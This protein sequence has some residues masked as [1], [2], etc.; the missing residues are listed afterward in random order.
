[1][2]NDVDQQQHEWRRDERY[3]GCSGGVVHDTRPSGGDAGDIRNDACD[4]IDGTDELSGANGAFSG[5]GGSECGVSGRSESPDWWGGWIPSFN[6]DRIK[7]ITNHVFGHK[8]AIGQD[9]EEMGHKEEE[10]GVKREEDPGIGQMRQSLNAP[11]GK[12]I[13]NLGR[14]KPKNLGGRSKKVGDYEE[15]ERD[16]DRHKVKSGKSRGTRTEKREEKGMRPRSGDQSGSEQSEGNESSSVGIWRKT[17]KRITSRLGL[18]NGVCINKNWNN[19]VD[20]MGYDDFEYDENAMP[21]L[22]VDESEQNR[23]FSRRGTVSG[24]QGASC[25]NI[26]CKCLVITIGFLFVGC[27]GGLVGYFIACL[28]EYKGNLKSEPLYQLIGEKFVGN[29]T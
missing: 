24:N 28:F 25:C 15:G 20:Y 10:E 7:S 1:M 9:E 18:N 11:N 19:S 6:E 14:Y 5:D 12:T 21:L 3:A 29:S 16:T 27:L 22:L 17:L 4:G 8:D 26:F 23:R 13:N 2:E